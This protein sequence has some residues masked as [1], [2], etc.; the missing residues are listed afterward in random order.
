MHVMN[1]KKLNNLWLKRIKD[2]MMPLVFYFTSCVLN[3]F[4]TLIY[5]STRDCDNHVELPHFRVV[6]CS[7]CFVELVC[8]CWFGVSHFN[9]EYVPLTYVLII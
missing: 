9:S 7:K 6:L 1:I 4:R 8:L 5:P 2:Q 3:T